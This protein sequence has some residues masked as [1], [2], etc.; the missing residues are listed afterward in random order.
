MFYPLDTRF[1]ILLLVKSDEVG[2]RGVIK[3]KK[4]TYLFYLPSYII[5]LLFNKDGSKLKIFSGIPRHK[6]EKSPMMDPDAR[7]VKKAN[8]T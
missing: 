8:A 6:N 3:S 4:C 1:P 2:G 7:L 5:R